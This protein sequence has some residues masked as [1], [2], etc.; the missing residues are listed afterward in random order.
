V[1]NEPAPQ[2]TDAERSPFVEIKAAPRY[3]IGLPIVISVTGDNRSGDAEFYLMPPL[4]LT[5]TQGGH[6]Q[7]S[8]VPTGS[9]GAPLETGFAVGEEWSPVV[10]LGKHEKRRMVCDLSNMGVTFQPGRYDL[11]LTLEESGEARASNTVSLVLERLSPTDE[12]EATRLRRLAGA[13]RDFG[14]WAPFLKAHMNTVTVA[15]TFDPAARAQLALH[16]FLHRATWTPG[17]LGQIDPAPLAAIHGAN[18][19]AEVA[20]LTYELAHARKDPAAS[21]IRGQVL[22]RFPGLEHR[23]KDVDQGKG[24]L[25]SYR[26]NYGVTSASP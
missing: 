26:K 14:A 3:F 2:F 23:V 25:A 19:D 17:G 4:D 7:V 13:P 20:A 18:V 1:T 24:T 5:F 16:L 11:T 15:P 21:T 9:D 6:I 8:L 22:A 12:A 10:A